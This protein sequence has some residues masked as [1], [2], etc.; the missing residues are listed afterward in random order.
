MENYCLICFSKSNELINLPYCSCNYCSEC[1]INWFDSQISELSYKQNDKIRCPNILCKYIYNIESDILTNTIFSQNLKSQLNQNLLLKYLH[2][3]PDVFNCPNSNCNYFGFQDEIK[4]CSENFHC[5]V[6]KTEWC[7][8]KFN[9]ISKEPSNWIKKIVN[10]DFN[11]FF[12]NVYEEVFTESCPE[13]SVYI[14]RN[15]GCYHMTCKNCKFEFCWYCKQ[16][17][18]GHKLNICLMHILVKTFLYMSL[19]FLIV[20]KFGW[21]IVIFDFFI[22]FLGFIFKYIVLFNVFA[23]IF[24]LY[25]VYLGKY[26]QYRNDV[27]KKKNKIAVAFFGSA[28]LIV[29]IFIV[30][31]GYLNEILMTWMIEIVVIGVCYAI[32][33]AGHIFYSSWLALVE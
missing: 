2:L 17:C 27:K 15:G 4:I 1:I 25:A 24:G 7:P 31:K 18:N 3:T 32:S 28:A 9:N 8:S 16:K 12:S 5:G 29:F 10:T 6:C 22:I 21:H 13:C 23:I 33:V 26:I 30:K 11:D 14:S 20:C 19:A